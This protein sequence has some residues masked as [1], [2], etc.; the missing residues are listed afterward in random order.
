MATRHSHF[1]TDPRDPE[2]IADLC[3]F[4]DVTSFGL[5]PHGYG[6]HFD[7]GAG[8]EF[9]IVA[10]VDDGANS[11]I[12]DLTPEDLQAVWDRVAVAFDFRAAARAERE[13][14][15]L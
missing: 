9:E 15:D 5:E 11:V 3:A 4:F 14:E 2:E 13:P 6:E 10:V 7:P 1:V 12:D 8:P